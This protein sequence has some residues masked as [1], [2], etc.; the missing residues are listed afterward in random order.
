MSQMSR[1]AIVVTII[2]LIAATVHAQE[3]GD[4]A[5]GRTLVQA[6]KCFECH[7]V[8]DTGSRVGP[9]LSDIGSRRTADRL[10]RA[11]VAPDDEVLPENRFVRVI[12]KDGTTVTGKLLNQDGFSIQ[13]MNPDEQLKTYLKAGLREFAIVQKG[14]MPA[15][16]GSAAQTADIVSYLGTLRGAMGAKSAMGATGTMSAMSAMGAAEA[17]GRI[18]I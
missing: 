10:T 14:L 3:A 7:R 5:N 15:F 2:V 6:N 13:L 11:L 9:D 4:P 8:G 18:I 12:T 16:E 1:C 17:A